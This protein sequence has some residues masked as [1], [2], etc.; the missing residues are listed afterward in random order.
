[1]RRFG[2]VHRTAELY[3]KGLLP[4]LPGD[5]AASVDLIPTEFAT[6][7]L[8]GLL[9]GARPGETYHIAAGEQAR[10]LTELW[11]LIDTHLQGRAPAWQR[12]PV[13]RRAIVDSATFTAA[14]AGL[15]A[16]RRFAL[17]R[18]Q[19]SVAAFAPQ[20]RLPKTFDRA[21]LRAALEATITEAPPLEAYLPR[22]LDY[23]IA[24]NWGRVMLRPEVAP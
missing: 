14:L 3:L 4:L 5:P 19:E 23:C 17:L 1:V 7:A 8:A 24:A 22:V 15:R 20:L 21:N 12:R 11:D 9:R 6:G 18:A 16:L 13:A 2:L 10:T